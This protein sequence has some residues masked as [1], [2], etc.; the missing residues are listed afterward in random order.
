MS[1]TS[2]RYERA[3]CWCQDERIWGD[4]AG[5]GE[6]GMVPGGALNGSQTPI[7]SSELV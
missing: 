3:V 1:D 6:I 7:E 2:E 5:S 4:T